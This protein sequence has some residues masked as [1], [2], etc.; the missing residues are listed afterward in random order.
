MEV[1]T[2][3]RLAPQKVAPLENRQAIHFQPSKESLLRFL[4][5]FDI[6]HL[7]QTHFVSISILKLF[8]SKANKI[9][10]SSGHYIV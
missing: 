2:G 1:K 10:H 9:S 8:L 3:G 5:P 7:K 6:R 4:F